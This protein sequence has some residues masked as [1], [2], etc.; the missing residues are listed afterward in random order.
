MAS[1][2]VQLACCLPNPTDATS[3]YRAMGPLS[4]L[5]N[6][7]AVEL[8]TLAAFNWAVMKMM[9]GLFLQR[10]HTS[11][12]VRLIALAQSM[13]KPVWIDFDDDLFAVPDCNPTQ[14]FYMKQS[15]Q[16]DI[17]RCLVRADVV[18]VSTAALQLKLRAIFEQISKDDPDARGNVGKIVTVPNAYDEDLMAPLTA[19]Y[20]KQDKAVLWRGSQTHDGDLEAHTPDIAACMEKHPTWTFV[21]VGNPFWKTIRTLQAIDAKRVVVVPAMDPI[22]YLKFMAATKPALVMVPL[23]DSPF[24]RAKSSCVWLE[25][26]H[27]GAVTLAPDWE[28]WHRPGILN[29]DDDFGD[30]LDG[31]MSGKYNAE[32]AVLKSRKYIANGMTV[33][34]ANDT[35]LMILRRMANGRKFDEL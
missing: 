14:S 9:D 27:A 34:Q 32:D 29:Y 23:E 12:H 7:G 19:K 1:R 20:G 26:T 10:P 35:R 25:A 22:D 4:P 21:F 17:A 33:S 16:F 2:P 3:L 30:E 31:F 11:D 5:A 24:N 28:E 13:R 6:A 8:H 18:T 15:V